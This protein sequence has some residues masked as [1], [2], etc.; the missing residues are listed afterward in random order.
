MSTNQ[1]YELAYELVQSIKH[2]HEYKTY[3]LLE[4]EIKTDNVC[5]TLITSFNKEKEAFELALTYGKYYPG[6]KKVL[7]TY[8]DAKIALLENSKIKQYKQL[9]RQID[10]ILSDITYEFKS[11]LA[12]QSSCHSGCQH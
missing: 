4:D 3:C 10:Q 12:V 6:Y 7:A 5:Q 2:S 11:A 1:L 8:R 9:E